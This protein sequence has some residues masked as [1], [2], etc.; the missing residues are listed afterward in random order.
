ML[1]MRNGFYSKNEKSADTEK[2]SADF[3][4][5]RINGFCFAARYTKLRPYIVLFIVFTFLSLGLL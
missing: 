4:D 1:R 2:V 3:C 5:V